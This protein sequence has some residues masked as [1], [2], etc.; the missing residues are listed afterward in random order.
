MAHEITMLLSG[1]WR[2]LQLISPYWVAGL[3]VG[4]L[5]S[6]YLSGK[7]ATK[8]SG[9]TGAKG[10]R[11]PHICAAS[12]LGIASPLCM[13]GT[14]PVI[15]AL[16]KKG[17]P[18]YLLAAF[19]VSSVM[20]NP[21][22]LLLT[23]VLGRNLALM[24]FAFVLVAGVLAG[25]LVRLFGDG[26]RLFLFERFKAEGEQIKK[27]ILHDLVKAFRVTA[28][29]LLLGVALTAVLDRYIPPE[30]I[31][32][33][34]GARR[35]LGVLFATTLSIP[36]YAC[37]GGVIPLINAWLHVGMGRGDALAFMLA[38]PA[39]KINSLSAVKMI[40]GRRIFAV[41]LAYCLVFSMVAGLLIEWMM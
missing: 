22:L 14:V 8:V 32:G 39:T 20:L 30:W 9:L 4:S 26:K 2:Q 13:F 21:N 24:R 33:M 19:M 17:L 7:I 35:G 34:F 28:P 3:L 10:L 31:Y 18:A 12:L 16:G 38:G 37:G 11:L 5:V 25:V 29:Y 36:L 15:A 1:I 23:V 6:V 40:L 27:S 41:Y